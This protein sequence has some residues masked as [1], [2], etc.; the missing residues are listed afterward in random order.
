MQGE[1]RATVDGLALRPRLRREFNATYVRRPTPPPRTIL[2]ADISA[3]KLSRAAAF[4]PHAKLADTEVINVK[5]HHI[6]PDI[7]IHGRGYNHLPAKPRQADT[8][9]QA[10]P[11]KQPLPASR[12]QRFGNK[13]QYAL[14]LAAVLL[15]CGGA[16]LSF[17]GWH[18]NEIVRAQAAQLTQEANKSSVPTS[19]PSTVKPTATAVANYVV[20]PGLPRYLTIPKLGVHARILSVGV[21]ASG[22]LGTPY[23]VYDTAWYNESSLPGQ[24]G[25]ML[26]DGHVSSW[27]AHGVFYGLKTLVA[28]DIIQVER[29]DGKMFTYKVVKSQ[30]YPSGKVNM[31]AALTPIIPGKPGLNLITC[32]G[33]VIPGT[34]EFNERIVVYATQIN[35]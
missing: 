32:T 33:D 28:G 23:N 20:A 27:T 31:A 4:T 10:E 6:A 12:R 13:L 29:G 24:P 2:I 7:S 15:I 30:V 34:S 18:S 11:I 8:P 14:V 5:Q 1:A 16:Y 3:R 26:I 9:L 35:P 19:V 21:L 25:A 17:V 22:A